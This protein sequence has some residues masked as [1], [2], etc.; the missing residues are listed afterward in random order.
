MSS[1]LSVI[2][3]NYNSAA[4]LQVCLRSMY[5]YL[6]PI[7]PEVIVVD[8]NSPER[9]I[10]DLP[11]LFPSVKFFL[12][13]ENLGFSKA[14]NFAFNHAQF[15]NILFLNPDTIFFEDCVSDLINFIDSMPDA[16]ACGVQLLN[17]DKSFQ[18]SFGKKLGFIYEAAEALMLIGLY[19]KI[20]YNSISKNFAKK[21]PFKVEWLSGAFLLLRKRTFETVGGFSDEFFLNYEDIDLCSMISKKGFTN[22]YFP[23]NKIIHLDSKSQKKN[24]ERFVLN[25]Y[26]SRL[27]FSRKHYSFLKRFFVRVIHILG[28]ILRIL[29]MDLFYKGKEKYQRKSG[30]KKSFLLYFGYKSYEDI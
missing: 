27:I 1:N 21:G 2:I 13:K 20:Y 29:T 26:K 5:K 23:R 24:Y 4:D 3:V 18:F 16:G 25:R 17:A 28:L 15:D 9:D 22:Y 12:L 7:V 30:Y 8:N 11:A 10:E 14:N 6:N 19:R